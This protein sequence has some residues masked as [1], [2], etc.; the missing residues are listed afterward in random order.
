[1]TDIVTITGVIGRPTVPKGYR[2]RTTASDTQWIRAYYGSRQNFERQ[3]RL[4]DRSTEAEW[5]LTMS[6]ESE[7][8]LPSIEEICDLEDKLAVVTNEFWADALNLPK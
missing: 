1:M 3:R 7:I 5:F 4:E 8:P 6:D 2:V